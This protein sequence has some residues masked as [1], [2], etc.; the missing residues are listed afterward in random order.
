MHTLE[1]KWKKREGGGGKTERDYLDFVIDDVSLS[2][3][4]GDFISCL[5]WSLQNEKNVRCLLLKEPAD[6]T[7]NRRS[8]YV[9]P[10]CGDLGCGAV[11]IVIEQTGNQIIWRNFAFEYS[12]SDDLTEYQNLGPFIFDKADY[13]K[14]LK[15]AL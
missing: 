14:V 11:S 5:G 2:E 3:K 1:L 7:N 13:E 4:F 15:S 8:L 10:E 9:C 12:Y 6:F